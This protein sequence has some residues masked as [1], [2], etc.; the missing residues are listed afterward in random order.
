[1]QPDLDVTTILDDWVRGDSSA[2]DRLTPLVY[3]QLHALAKSQLR[4]LGRPITLQTTDVVGELFVKLLAK[5][6]DR[7][8]SR[9]HFYAMAAKM[10]RF[11][12]V[13]HYRQSQTEKRGGESQRVPLH[14]EL[15]WVDAAGVEMLTFE[16]AMAELESLDRQQAELF[17]MRFLV[18]CTAGE[19]AEMTGLSKATVDRKVRLARAW[20][21]KRM[22]PS[23]AVGC[24]SNPAHSTNS[25]LHD[26]E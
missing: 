15:S 10:I 13:D 21:F 7:F 17:G 25:R 3:P 6:P 18:G 1:M 5:R 8:E 20:L 16:S 19:A 2:L 14:E 26:A 4:R 24:E 9:G 11:A 23:A 12:L 22:N